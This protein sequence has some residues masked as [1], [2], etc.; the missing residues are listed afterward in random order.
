MKRWYVV[1]TKT[2]QEAKA[3]FNLNCQGFTTYVPRYARRI[4]HARRTQSVLRPLF[5]G[6]V[7]V[8]LDF[9]TQRWRSVQG[10]FGVVGFVQFGD[11]PT[12]VPNELLE[13][14]RDREDQIGAI[15]IGHSDLMAGDRVRILDGPF[16]DQCAVL[17]EVADEDRVF[18][19]LELMKR[20]VRV[21]AS[22]ANLV[23]A[24]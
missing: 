18:L 14:M 10:T 7:F 17:L 22:K 11:R 5:P 19:L 3:V 20:E 12:P 2:G 13:S 24:S 1:R 4:R 21:S 15:Q 9:E 23:K 6:Y 16:A 8:Q